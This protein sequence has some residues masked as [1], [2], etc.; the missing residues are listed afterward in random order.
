M[1]MSGMTREPAVID[2]SE[3]CRAAKKLSRNE[4]KN[5]RFLERI[6]ECAYAGVP[7]RDCQTDIPCAEYV[8][9]VVCRG[10][11]SVLRME[12]PEM[13]R[14]QCPACGRRGAITHWKGVI[15]LSIPDEDAVRDRRE[16]DIAELVLSMEEFRC[17]SVI[18]GLDPV[19]HWIVRGA[20]KCE[21]GI[22]LYGMIG[23]LADLS[24]VVL[25][26]ISLSS[27]ATMIEIYRALSDKISSLIE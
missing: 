18:P 22:L 17:L 12:V 5:L 9:G 8:E 23:E 25:R 6:I 2:L 13:I 7:G 21:R 20:V 27:D 3:Y 15:P 14:Y 26:E 16:Y 11:I 24:K 10:S 19:S 1:I 4:K